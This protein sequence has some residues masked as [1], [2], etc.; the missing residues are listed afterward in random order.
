MTSASNA[1]QAGFS[2]L[3]MSIVLAIVGLLLAGLLPSVS[4]QIEQQRRNETRKQLDEIKDALIGYAIVNGRLPCPALA[5]AVTNTTSA[6]ETDCT[7]ATGIIA[8]GVIPWVTLGTSETD[9][10]GRRFTYATTSTFITSNFTLA[11]TGNLTVKN[12]A[13]GTSIASNMPAVLIA[14]G[15]NGYGAYTTQGT[16]LSVSSDP[17]E[18]ENS[19][20][21]ATFVSHDFTPS[22]DDLVVWIPPGI[23]FNRMVSAGKLP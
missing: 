8:T 5:S 22:F 18:A 16:Q 17:D 1:H 23:L 3:E 14:H 2:L 19:N 4:G 6:G 11:S 7:L 10:W 13:T 9:A 21:N 20:A 12:S 15:A